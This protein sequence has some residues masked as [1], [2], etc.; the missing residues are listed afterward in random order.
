MRLLLDANL[1][2]RRIA[3]PLRASG[4]DVLALSERPDLEGMSD[5]EVLAL[6]VEENRI[7]VT[8]NRKDFAPLLREWSGAGRHHAGCVLIWT[9]D[10][11]EFGRISSRVRQLLDE[12]PKQRD[13]RD[14]A[15]A[16]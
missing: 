5:P 2:G 12:R 11:H 1:S 6:A 16:I 9:L 10:H 7:L 4:H 15:A 8:R 3:G 13:W 14:I